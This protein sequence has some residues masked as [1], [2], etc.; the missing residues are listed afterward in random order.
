M[1]ALDYLR[2]AWS[3]LRLIS[4]IKLI[5]VT[6]DQFETIVDDWLIL[7]DGQCQYAKSNIVYARAFH[8]DAIR[9]FT[10]SKKIDDNRL[11]LINIL[12][13]N[14]YKYYVKEKPTH[15]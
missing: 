3:D 1:T 7:D 11:V 10:S 14:R 9:Y 15:D 12:S 8:L 6:K 2:I 5:E 13:N 4:Y